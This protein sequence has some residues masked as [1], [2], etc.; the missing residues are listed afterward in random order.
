MAWT[1]E[2]PSCFQIYICTEGR[3]LGSILPESDLINYHL[4]LRLNDQSFKLMMSALCSDKAMLFQQL[5]FLFFQF[6]IDLRHILM[7]LAYLL[8][9]GGINRIVNW[10]GL[11][12]GIVRWWRWLAGFVF[13][14]WLWFHSNYNIRINNDINLLVN[15]F[16]AI[17]Q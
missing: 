3:D 2:I 10:C 9:F 14:L 4:I 5:L 1:Y 12:R 11:L 7:V 15:F 17:E 13:N 6:F 16:H 8:F